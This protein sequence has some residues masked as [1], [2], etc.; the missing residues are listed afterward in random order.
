[1]K[2]NKDREQGSIEG[3]TPNK[4]EADKII[5]TG[6]RILDPKDTLEGYVFVGEFTGKDETREAHTSGFIK[7]LS[8]NE[9]ANSLFTLAKNAK[10]D[11]LLLHHFIDD[12]LSSVIEK[13]N[14]RAD[15]I[16]PLDEILKH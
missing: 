6:K 3:Y 1:M 10:V 4:Q 12:A 13:I 7:G 14:G 11:S 5:Y 16:N 2:I 8:K 9:I 15:K